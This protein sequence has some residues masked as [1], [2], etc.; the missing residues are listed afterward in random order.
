MATASSILLSTQLSVAQTAHGCATKIITVETNKRFQEA[1]NLA[2]EINRREESA[3]TFVPVGDLTGF[4]I[5]MGY[6]VQL[7]G[8]PGRVDYMFSVRDLQDSCNVFFSD[9]RGKIYLGQ[10]S[11]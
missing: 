11:N 6:A 9:Q 8:T 5:P 2:L 4:V 10:P 7:H 1:R 3:G